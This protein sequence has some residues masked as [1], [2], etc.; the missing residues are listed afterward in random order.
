MI[1]WDWLIKWEAPIR[2][3]WLCQSYW[4]QTKWDNRRQTHFNWRIQTLQNSLYPH[5]PTMTS[6]ISRWNDNRDIVMYTVWSRSAAAVCAAMMTRGAQTEENAS[7]ELCSDHIHWRLISHPPSF[8]PASVCY[9]NMSRTTW[10]ILMKL[11]ENYHWKS[12]WFK[13]AATPNWLTNRKI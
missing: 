8:S 4:L 6:Q 9:Q 1:Q 13:M 12:T 2:H 7:Q 11:A 5:N 3:V 10:C